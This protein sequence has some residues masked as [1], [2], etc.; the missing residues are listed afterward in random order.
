MLQE[1]AYYNATRENLR[2]TVQDNALL[3]AQ[4]IPMETIQQENV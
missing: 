1:I 2:I 3:F 4:Q